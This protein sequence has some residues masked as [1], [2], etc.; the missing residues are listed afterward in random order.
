MKLFLALLLIVSTNVFS[1]NLKWSSLFKGTSYILTQDIEI[2]DRKEDFIIGINSK[3][4][5]IESNLLPMINVHLFKFEL[6]NC[7]SNSMKT[8]LELLELA[9]EN[10][11]IVVIGYDVIESCI[12][13]VFIEQKDMY[14]KSIF[15]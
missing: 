8:E 1:K 11:K 3:L 9:Q 6:P 5:L 2:T 7:P 4:R 15:K 14:T 10:D 13:E 12:F